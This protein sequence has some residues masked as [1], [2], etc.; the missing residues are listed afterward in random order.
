MVVSLPREKRLLRLELTGLGRLGE[1]LAEEQGKPVFVFGGIPGETVQAKVVRER[2]GYLAARVVE[3]ETA[4]PHRV[5]PPCPYFGPCTGCQWQHIDYDHQ[6]RM[7]RELVREALERV[8]GLTDVPVDETLASPGPWGY[9]NHAR[10]TVGHEGRLGFVNR[11]T[12]ELVEVDECL[13][14]DPW[15][16]QTLSSLQ[17]H[18][19]ETTQLSIRYGVN[20]G[21]WMVQPALHDP[22]LGFETGQQTYEEELLGERFRVA[23]P[24]F[25]QVNSRQAEQLALL[26]RESLALT[27]QELVVDA[28][29]GV[30]TFAVLLASHAKRVIA[31]E[32]SSAALKDAR[33][34]AASA[35][36]VEIRKGK[37]EQMLAEIAQ[38][39][40]DAIVLDPP[41]AGCHPDVLRALA[42]AA[43][44]RIAYVS[45]D[46]ETLACDLAILVAGPF[47]I[48]RVQPVD[49]FPQTHHVECLAILVLDPARQAALEARANLVLASASP[50]RHEILERLGLV[51]EPSPVDVPEPPGRLQHDDP[52]GLAQSR[53]LQKA[54]AAAESRSG[55]TVIG[56][57]TV[58]AMDDVVMGKPVDAADAVAMLREL[59]GREHRVVTGV[60]LVDAA[61]GESLVG[62]RSSRVRMREYTDQEIQAYVD[63]GD[64]LDKVGAYA[65]QSAVFHPAAEVRG[66]Y[67]NVVGLPVCT[68]MKQLERF[69]VSGVVPDAMSG[70]QNQP[71]LGDWS[72]LH[73]CRECSQRSAGAR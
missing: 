56:A 41:R 7:K 45:C 49:M 55:G 23:S 27:G 15:I 34:N 26:L 11:E 52:V 24:S 44:R 1:A 6:L 46:P 17:G 33:H 2:R 9:R 22:D 51:F 62:H 73:R 20:T 64:P 70:P 59:R 72:D 40:V 71:I 42:T 57:D 31:I 38:D 35:L 60:A 36:N 68:L 50:R 48:E 28:Y 25:F 14:M 12:R 32:E 8:G 53:A 67:L 21:S 61:S 66:C 4:S 65:V 3:V 19:R 69:G 16:N 43:P 54:L 30:G 47:R 63:S 18:A 29:A 10:F 5:A 58:V 37:V 39:G 13:L